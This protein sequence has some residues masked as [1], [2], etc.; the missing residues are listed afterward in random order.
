VGSALWFVGGGG[1]GAGAGA[2]ANCASWASVDVEM[3]SRI[4]EGSRGRLAARGQRFLVGGSGVGGWGK[5]V[6]T[7]T[8]E[9]EGEWMGM[10]V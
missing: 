1:G 8:K 3:A 9:D 4:R 10:G 6:E 2:R 5:L 7:E